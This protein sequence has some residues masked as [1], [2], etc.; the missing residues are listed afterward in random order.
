[1]LDNKSQNRPLEIPLAFTERAVSRDETGQLGGRVAQQ[2]G[3]HFCVR[4]TAVYVGL[5]SGLLAPNNAR[6][7]R[8]VH[9]PAS[10]L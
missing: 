3:A 10:P 4:N 5:T 7:F 8:R 6:R 2:G 1:M 9:L